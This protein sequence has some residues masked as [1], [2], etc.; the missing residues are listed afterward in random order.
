MK[1]EYITDEV[2]FIKNSERAE[3]VHISISANPI[4][5]MNGSIIGGSVIFR[6]VSENIKLEMALKEQQDRFQAQFKN[7][8]Q[9]TYVWQN[10]ED[11]YYLIDY[12][13]AAEGFN[14][15][16]IRKYIGSKLS[17]MYADT[18]QIAADFR[19]C[20]NSKSALRR[21]MTYSRNGK[22]KERYWIINYVFV[23]PDLIMVHTED[24]T[25]RKET[26]ESLRKLSSAVEQTADSV[27]LT[28]INGAIE[29]VNSSFEKTTGYAYSEVIG[30]TPAILKSDMQ[31][32]E[33]Y[34]ILWNTIL[35]GNPHLG[36]IIN[37]KKMVNYIGANSRSRQ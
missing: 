35:S 11:D 27:L 16:S 37:K 32:P 24:I 6:D 33:Y 22:K 9:P 3:G 26:E 7:F 30:K 14:Q 23:P 12:N 34:E 31:D 19:L 20:F 28:D 17:A 1:G 13:H 5:D 29:Y 25:E 10:C 8:P 36:T 2:I 18:P 4:R 21:E 15:G